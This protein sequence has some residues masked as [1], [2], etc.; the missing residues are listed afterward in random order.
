M[1]N[2]FLIQNVN[3]PI[4]LN[5]ILDLVLS[6]EEN[7]VQKVKDGEHIANSDH[8]II[9]GEI[10]ITKKL[11]ENEEKIYNY[12]RGNFNQIREKLRTIDWNH[13][14]RNKTASDMLDTFT[15]KLMKLVDRYV[16]K[17]TRR[18]SGKVQPKWFTREIKQALV[19]KKILFQIQESDSTDQ[20]KRE[21][22]KVRREVQKKIRQ[23]KRNYE[24]K[25]ADTCKENP[26]AFYA[27]VSKK[28]KTKDSIGP[29]LDTDNNLEM[30]TGKMAV[31]LNN[32][33]TSVFT[34]EDTRDIPVPENIFNRNEDCKLTT[35]DITDDD[36]SKCID[37]LKI[38]KS[39]GPDKISPR[40]IKK[41]KDELIKPLK[42]IF[43]TSLTTGQVPAKWKLANVTPI[44]KKKGMKKLACNYRPISLTSIIGKLMETILRDQIVKHL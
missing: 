7:L 1:H 28:K 13:L 20:N 19:Q 21:Y 23:S 32:Q 3:E 40:V 12:K 33:F 27:Y 5:N 15:N 17:Q 11:E 30:D 39:P 42:I 31:I 37:K 41:L 16:P 44:F 25:I 10:N 9:R 43:N 24:K 18:T 4:R 22:Y 6:T 29:L 26:K 35:Y 36:I 8:N 2:N 14:F 38:H 34:R